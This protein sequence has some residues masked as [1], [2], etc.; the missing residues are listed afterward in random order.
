MTV[1]QIADLWPRIRQDVKALNRRI[2]ALLASV[3]PVRV[4]GD[5]V[6]LAAAYPFHRDKLN[7]DDVRSVVE[8]VISRL[9]GRAVKVQC[10]L[11]DELPAVS[12][13]PP[14]AL[15]APANGIEPDTEHDLPAAAAGAAEP[16]AHLADAPPNG[17]PD[18]DEAAYDQ[19][20]QAA[21]NIFDA[22]IIE[23]PEI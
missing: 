17:S 12:Q 14:A 7:S 10:S 13:P 2:E 4:S 22:E 11:R 9:A 3:D 20:V 16:P 18:E 19:R 21:R 15:M 23:T 5:A 6:I 8:S 1:E